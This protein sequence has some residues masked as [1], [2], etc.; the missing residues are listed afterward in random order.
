MDSIAQDLYTA[1][2]Y[3]A[4]RE[5]AEIRALTDDG[6]FSI[7]ELAYAYLVGKEFAQRQ[8]YE[9]GKQIK[10]KRE[11]R[12]GSGPTDLV[13]EIPKDDGD[14]L[15]IA[16]EFKVRSTLP[17]YR[18]DLR[19]LEAAK[20]GDQSIDLRIFLALV[21]RFIG[22]EDPRIADIDAEVDGGTGKWKP[23]LRPISRF[24][25]FETKTSSYSSPVECVVAAW[26]VGGSDE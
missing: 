6:V 1:A 15:V 19:K 26:I 5:D 18:A 4:Q 22:R 20:Y 13:L 8:A 14:T 11:T 12:L 21:D 2:V 9:K 7:P 23:D 17:K 24:I 10:W 25:Q 3:V 16:V